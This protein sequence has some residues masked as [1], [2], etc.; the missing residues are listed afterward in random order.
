MA[1]R[2]ADSNTMKERGIGS[3]LA[4]VEPT[5]T[6]WFPKSRPEM[7]FSI[8]IRGCRLVDGC[9][10]SAL[11]GMDDSCKVKGDDDKKREGINKTWPVEGTIF[12]IYTPLYFGQ[13][14]SASKVRVDLGS[15]RAPET[16][17]DLFKT[18]PSKN[19]LSGLSGKLGLQPSQLDRFG[20]GK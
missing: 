6:V 18:R 3:T 11:N 13:N 19:N 15:P 16:C 5:L 12:T 8:G 14:A 9:G 7:A 1:E 20:T 17:E 2:G 4:R 10:A